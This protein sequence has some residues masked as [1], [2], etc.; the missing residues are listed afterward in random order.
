MILNMNNR[1]D[2]ILLFAG[3]FLFVLGWVFYSESVKDDVQGAQTVEG[4]DL[5]HSST[6]NFTNLSFNFVSFHGIQYLQIPYATEQFKN[7][8][9]FAVIILPYLGTLDSSTSNGWHYV[10]IPSVNATLLY[11]YFEFN[12]TALFHADQGNLYFYFK[13][14]IESKQYYVHSINIPFK[15]PL[16]ILD[17]ITK[18][19]NRSPDLWTD[20]WQFIGTKNVTYTVPSNASE[21]NPVPDYG[22]LQSYDDKYR[23]VH[24]T[25]FLWKIPDDGITFHVDYVL[26]EE[27]KKFDDS[28]N[29]SLIFF[30]TSAAM[31]STF[32]GNVIGS[33]MRKSK[34]HSYNGSS[35]ENSETSGIS[36]DDTEQEQLGLRFKIKAS[37]A[38][39]GVIVLLV[40]FLYYVSLLPCPSSLFTFLLKNQECD[41]SNIL[42]VS[43]S[44]IV[45]GVF[46]IIL[47]WIFYSKQKI[48]SNRI[49][50][51]ATK[52][53]ALTEQLSQINQ[54]VTDMEF[55]QRRLDG[56]RIL[57]RNLRE[58]SAII[59][60]IRPS[61]GRGP[62]RPIRH[63]NRR[64]EIVKEIRQ[65]IDSVSLSRDPHFPLI[66]TIEEF[67]AF[68]LRMP[69]RNTVAMTDAAFTVPADLDFA[70]FDTRVNVMIQTL[71]NLQQTILDR[72]QPDVERPES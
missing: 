23:N 22:N 32:V 47:S 63:L 41:L 52:E 31:L 61:E 21:L 37:I 39:A 70:E 18:I 55:E 66:P 5:I 36:N 46:A 25:V 51:L 65:V 60:I 24:A 8:N 48:D 68:V 7:D 49:E 67:C 16:N 58:L 45:A 34:T 53:L 38:I 56:C 33:H 20:G 50:R 28:R 40:N 14:P 69:D 1:S 17:N 71:V 44:L 2:L 29:L 4:V 54:R 64:D 3:V 43:I 26:P 57:I 19:A 30:G 72:T 13:N 35:N 62:F 10:P 9:P 15:R 27:R 11:K 59:E 6:F 12:E 42:G